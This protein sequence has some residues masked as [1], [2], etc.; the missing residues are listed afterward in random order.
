MDI[1]NFRWPAGK[2]RIERLAMRAIGAHRIEGI[3]TRRSVERSSF[4]GDALHSG[5]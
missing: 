2:T 1:T 4:T 3:A 5:A